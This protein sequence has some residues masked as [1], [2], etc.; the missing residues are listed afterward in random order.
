MIH[1]DG[2]MTE[3]DIIR[4]LEEAARRAE[5]ETDEQYY[6][7]RELV[8]MTGWPKSRM[9]DVLGQLK[10][11]GRLD[12]RRKLRENLAGNAYYAP[13]YRILPPPNG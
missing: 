4:E 3:D 9:W 10:D 2:S 13:A 12:I 5:E 6:T 11:A 1:R 8:E 7:T